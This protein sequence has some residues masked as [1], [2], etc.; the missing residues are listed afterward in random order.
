MELKT[1]LEMCYAELVEKKDRTVTTLLLVCWLHFCKIC[2]YTL[3]KLVKLF[4]LIFIVKAIV[5]TS[6]ENCESKKLAD[7][8]TKG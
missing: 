4:K 7:V 1:Y 8:V 6:R 2:G 5:K 3:D